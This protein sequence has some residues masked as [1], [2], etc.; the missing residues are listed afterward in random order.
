[1]LSPHTRIISDKE[2][3]DTVSPLPFDSPTGTS[4]PRVSGFGR[5]PKRSTAHSLKPYARGRTTSIQRAKVHATR[6]HV[7]AMLKLGKVDEEI[8]G[9]R[10]RLR[11]PDRVLYIPLQL[12][13][14]AIPLVGYI[15]CRSSSVVRLS[16]WTL[17]PKLMI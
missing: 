10:R 4:K 1:M 2:N 6:K 11:Q 13:K 14:P 12:P 15:D 5:A 16:L 17:E 3:A 9:K 7:P 8:S